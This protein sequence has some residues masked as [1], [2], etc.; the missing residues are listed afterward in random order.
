MK[1]METAL[2]FFIGSAFGGIIVYLTSLKEMAAVTV[3]SPPVT[4]GKVSNLIERLKP[5]AER[6]N[7]DWRGVAVTITGA[8]AKV[9]IKTKDGNEYTGKGKTLPDAVRMIDSSKI[10]DALTGWGTPPT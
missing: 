7:D 2:A 6:P 1:R 9:D 8:S 4:I 5:L 10:R 3:Q